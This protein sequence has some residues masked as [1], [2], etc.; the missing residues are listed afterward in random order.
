MRHP[1]SFC[2]SCDVTNLDSSYIRTST[3]FFLLQQLCLPTP[4]GLEYRADGF[5]NFQEMAVAVSR[6]YQGQANRH[7]VVSLE[8]RNIEHGTMQALCNCQLC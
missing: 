7:V 4:L 5:A 8:A 1:I 3:I 2:L 6:C